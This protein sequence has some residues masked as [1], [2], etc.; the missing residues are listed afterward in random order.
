M[1]PTAALQFER[2]D[3]WWKENREKNPFLF[4]DE[5]AR[6]IDFL[7]LDPEGGFEIKSR[8]GRHFRRVPLERCRN[9]I[10]YW[11]QPGDERV[12]I[13]AFWGGPQKRRP[14]LALD[15]IP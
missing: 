2:L 12:W 11:H 6:A 10:Y 7:E 13:V 15:E 4:A 1:T 9:Q 8:A 14:R 3:A 5:V